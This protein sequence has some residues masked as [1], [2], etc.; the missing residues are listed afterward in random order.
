MITDIWMFYQLYSYFKKHLLIG[1]QQ[2]SFWEHLQISV[3]YFAV[4]MSEPGKQMDLQK[5]L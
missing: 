1:I 5:Q 2:I 3:A 4:N